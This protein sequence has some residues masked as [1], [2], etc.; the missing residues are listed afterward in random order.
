MQGDTSVFDWRGGGGG[1][2]GGGGERGEGSGYSNT[3]LYMAY[4]G[5]AAITTDYE[6][7]N[8]ESVCVLALKT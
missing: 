6:D 4:I 3:S 2:G 7:C 5:Y 8:T 1:G